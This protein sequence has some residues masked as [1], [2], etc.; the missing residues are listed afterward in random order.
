MFL[1]EVKNLSKHFG[2][3]KA[4]NDVTFN[5]KERNIVGLIGPNGAGKTTTFSMIAGLVSPTSGTI[6]FNQKDITKIPAYKVVNCGIVCTFQKTKVFPSLSVEDAVL[7][8]THC[9]N[10]TSISDIIWRTKNFTAN[11]SR[12]IEKVKEVLNYTGLYEKRKYMCTGL[13][14]GEQRVLEIAVAMA[15]DPTLLL[16]DEPAAGLNRKE[17][18][19]LMAM[20]SGLKQAGITILL[21]EHDMSVVMQI[22]DFVVVLNFGEKIA[23][24]TPAEVTRNPKVIEAYLGPGEKL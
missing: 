15:S 10:N 22:S 4:V 7:I 16:L 11:E 17:S 19:N 21:I 6:L 13:S 1:L 12:A 20:I 23:S 9:K 24:G 18:E 8:G 2:G 14:Y 5:V 3:L